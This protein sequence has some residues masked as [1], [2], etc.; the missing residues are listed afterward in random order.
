MYHAIS[1]EKQ[2]INW[3][4]EWKNNLIEKVNLQWLDLTTDW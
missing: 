3:R 1:R 4:R 2:L